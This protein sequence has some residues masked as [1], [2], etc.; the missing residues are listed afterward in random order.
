MWR[1]QSDWLCHHTLSAISLQ[2]VVNKMA[3]FSLFPKFPEEDLELRQEVKI[4]EWTD[5]PTNI[6]A[7]AWSLK[8]L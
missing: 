3:T 7:K 6:F 5:E 8:L 1:L 2:I 4:V